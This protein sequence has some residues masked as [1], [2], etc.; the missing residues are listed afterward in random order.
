MTG[1]VQAAPVA[2]SALRPGAAP[3][4]VHE[5]FE[6]H[7]RA[8]PGAPAV[9]LSD[10]EISY[11]ELNALAN[12]LAHRLRD[13]GVGPERFVGLCAHRSV[14]TLAAILAVLK[15]G[16][17]L[18][19]LDP[20]DP[21]ERLEGMI[22]DAR[23][24][25]VLA[26][27]QNRARFGKEGTLWLDEVAGSAEDSD[28]RP[29]AD[30]ANA[31]YALYTSGSSGAAKGVVVEHRGLLNFLTWT[32][33]SLLRERSLMVPVISRLTLAP[34]FKQLFA[35]WLRGDP[36]WLPDE[37]VVADPVALLRALSGR[38]DV[39]L[40]CVP[41][42]WQ[43]MLEA[44]A[45]GLA[46]VPDTL[47]LVCLQG[48]MPTQSLVDRSFAALDELELWNVYGATE[49][50]IATAACIRPGDAVSI[51]QPIAG[52][53]AHV[54]DEELRPVAADEAG[55]LHVGGVGLAR[56]YLSRPALTA[57]RFIPDPLADE[58]GARL[59][60]TGDIGRRTANGELRFVARRDRLMKIRGFRVE[61]SEVEEAIGRHP[62]VARCAVA[63]TRD[64]RGGD[65][66]LAYAVAE[67]RGAPTL[68]ELRGFLA[69]KLPAYMLPSR[70]IVLEA[71]PRAASWKIDRRELERMGDAHHRS[72]ETDPARLAAPSQRR[73]AHGDIAPRNALELELVGMWERLLDVRPIGVE[74]DFFEL[75]GDSLLAVRLLTEAR[76]RFGVELPM[77]FHAPTVRALAVAV[78]DG[79]GSAWRSLVPLNAY[80][81]RRPFFFVSPHTGNV[82]GFAGLARHLGS[83]R[84]FYALQ[85]QGLDGSAAP[86]TR[87]EDM[88]AHYL[89]EIRSVQGSGPYLVGGRCYGG[90]V[91]FE[92]ARQL[93]A[94]REEVALLALLEAPA[95]LLPNH[96]AD[97]DAAERGSDQVG[98]ARGRA[99]VRQPIRRVANRA[100]TIWSA[101]R[102]RLRRQRLPITQSLGGV[103]RVS[104]SSFER[105]T[106][107]AHRAYLGGSYSGTVVHFLSEESIALGLH[108]GWPEL[109]ENVELE[110][111]P[112]NHLTL[113]REPLVLVLAD[114]L[115]ARAE[116]AEASA[117]T[118][119]RCLSR[120]PVPA[121]A[122]CSVPSGRCSST[123]DGS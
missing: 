9:L 22:E 66:L 34:S 27:P 12:R 52:V 56:G 89:E 104:L 21:Q 99:A 54:L 76:S 94:A 58:P 47:R 59:F 73:P 49:M 114:S 112:G 90:R 96:R 113:V 60:K 42:L 110:R 11:A 118:R 64:A 95:D 82:V 91:A 97:L 39:A 24:H 65:R 16:G 25:I 45:A 108:H 86:H 123:S 75:G 6:A 80:G 87:V 48:E 103:E 107:A 62:G 43:A 2:A 1:R 63:G 38:R 106:Y 28:P 67:D 78:E 46:S 8:V 121:G 14:E 79:A 10:R 92:M 81:S 19:P 23:P 4:T 84:P 35:P 20:A 119:A 93:E 30:R 102:W 26:D 120:P 69:S 111:V 98:E 44:A 68:G 13:L 115:T 57:E 85:P 122:R 40:N 31:A 61:P 88:A 77:L 55:E 5:A 33:R 3:A 117:E 18:L 101:A 100:R 37:R 7:A 105:A 72:A 41:H 51:G 17:A 32:D 36:A 70:L 83:D 109:A 116:A 50:G 74:D 53:D 71:L 15:A 29:Q